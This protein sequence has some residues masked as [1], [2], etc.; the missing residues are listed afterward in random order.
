MLWLP[1]EIL[2]CLLA[3]GRLDSIFHRWILRIH[4]LLLSSPQISPLS[5]FII[6]WGDFIVLN[7]NNPYS[8]YI[9]EHPWI[10]FHIYK[11]SKILPAQ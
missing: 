5:P 8:L 4:L 3:D 11:T 9:L 7:T 2:Y 10:D 1:I 6:L